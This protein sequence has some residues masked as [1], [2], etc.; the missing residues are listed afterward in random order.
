MTRSRVV[1]LFLA[2]ASMLAIQVTAHAT[3]TFLTAID[4]S[5]AGQDGFE[6]QVT[7]DPVTGNVVAVWTRSDGTNLRIES[8][9]R[10]P[11][12]AWSAG[13]PIS[14]P[15]QSA[16]SPAISTD[17][18][19]NMLAVWTRFDGTN[20][21]IQAAYRPAGG[22]FG[23]PATVSTAG[24]DANQPQVS[25]DSGG[26]ALVTWIRFDGTKTRV[27][28]SVRGAGGAGTFSAP[29]TLNGPWE[30]SG[31]CGARPRAPVQRPRADCLS[32]TGALV[33]GSPPEAFRPAVTSDR[34]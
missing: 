16:S 25:M 4:I 21:R 8:A 27:Q 5:A 34:G 19:G 20:G 31:R 10:T 7:V 15:G 26:K 2:L 12:G 22:S 14:D 11:N 13:T 24:G 30:W 17:P 9:N 28:V 3:A 6:P 33:G 23:T 1:V 32:A 18:S 29:V